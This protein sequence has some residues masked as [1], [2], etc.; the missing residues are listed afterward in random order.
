M[1]DALSDVA[2]Y[3]RGLVKIPIPASDHIEPF[4][5]ENP[6]ERWVYY[7]C[8]QNQ[9][10]SN[11]FLAMSSARNRVIGILMYKFGITG[12][13]QWGYNFYFSQHSEYVVNPY[14]TTSSD[15]AFPSGDPFSVYPAPG[16]CILPCGPLC[17]MRDCRIWRCARHWRRNG[18]GIV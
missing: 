15:G 11:R 1:I 5:K 16:A 13:L 14:L 7:C 3:Q 17:S 10:V 6:P 2:F 18:A 4:L 9:G 12:F 8:G